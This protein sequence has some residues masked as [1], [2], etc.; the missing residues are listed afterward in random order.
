MGEGLAGATLQSR[1]DT[2]GIFRP[3]FLSVN[4]VRLDGFDQLSSISSP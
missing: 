4:R 1:W 3:Q 2:V